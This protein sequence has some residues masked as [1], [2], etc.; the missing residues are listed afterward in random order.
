VPEFWTILPELE[1]E[2]PE[3]V[4]LQQHLF[5]LQTTVGHRRK[6]H[7][8]IDEKVNTRIDTA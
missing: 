3:F 6:K 8:S 1:P 7:E 4:Q 5:V 2:F